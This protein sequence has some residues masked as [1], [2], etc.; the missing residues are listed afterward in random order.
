M[1][2][3]PDRST[4]FII[5]TSKHP[6][7]I[8]PNYSVRRLTIRLPRGWVFWQ[9]PRLL[10]RYIYDAVRNGNLLESYRT[11][12]YMYV[13][14]RRSS[15]N[16]T[17]FVRNVKFAF[18]LINDPNAPLVRV[19]NYGALWQVGDL[20]GIYDEGIALKSS[21]PERRT[22]LL[23]TYRLT[24]G[25]LWKKLSKSWKRFFSRRCSALWTFLIDEFYLWWITL[26]NVLD[27]GT[28]ETLI[29]TIKLRSFDWNL[30]KLLLY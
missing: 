16:A 29:L 11:Y 9:F 21:N 27:V 25:N 23:F 26:I 14:E 17:R 4:I 19:I 15:N 18:W 10:L 22:L 3:Y 2:N 8:R 6:G 28:F 20:A 12:I 7:V 1:Q 24:R 30:F 13:K 5:S